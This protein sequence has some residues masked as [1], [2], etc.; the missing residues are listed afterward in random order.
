VR[1]NDIA[2]ELQYCAR[3]SLARLRIEHGRHTAFLREQTRA[4]G[5]GVCFPGEGCSRCA[6]ERGMRGV[7][8][9]AVGFRG[10]G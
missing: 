7:V 4:Q 6:F 1:D 5:C 9:E 8:G 2:V 10:I 3:L